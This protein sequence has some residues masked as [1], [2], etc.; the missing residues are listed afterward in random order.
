M[1]EPEEITELQ[2]EIRNIILEETR[3]FLRRDYESWA[4]C[5]IHD[6]KSTILECRPAFAEEIT[7]WT[8]ISE[9]MKNLLESGTTELGDEVR[10]TDFSYRIGKDLAF[11]SFREN[12]NA[13][14]RLLKKTDNGWKICHVGVV[15]TSIYQRNGNY[16]QDWETR[17]NKLEKTGLIENAQ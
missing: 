1:I 2:K 6:E 16:I 9:Y 15:Y 3:C 14:T 11:V 17:N 7:G 12:G 8:R 5:W 4:G 13:S 10:K